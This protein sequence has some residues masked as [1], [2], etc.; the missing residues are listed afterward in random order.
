MT[1]RPASTSSRAART[2]RATKTGTSP[3]RDGEAAGLGA[4]VGEALGPGETE[5]DDDGDGWVLGEV[6]GDG[7]VC[8][9]AM[10]GLWQGSGRTTGKL[11]T[12]PGELSAR[13]GQPLLPSGQ[14]PTSASPWG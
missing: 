5:A 6:P 9:T 7:E 11:L 8:W 3:R 12:T 4:Q 10:R 14:R 13:G 1:T 2:T